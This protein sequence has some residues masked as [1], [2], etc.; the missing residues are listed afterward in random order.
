MLRFA[1]LLGHTLL[2][3]CF[4]ILLY[5][6][7][8]VSLSY[9][10]TVS[11]FH[12]FTVFLLSVFVFYCFRRVPVLVFYCFNVLQPIACTI[13]MAYNN[14]HCGARDRRLAGLLIELRS[15]DSGSR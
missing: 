14:G 15:R 3:Y 1:V 7:V 2:H 5:Y 8:T 11:L 9:W 4:T 10:F 12:C 13:I 6:R